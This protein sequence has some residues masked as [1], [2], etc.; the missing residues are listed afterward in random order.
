M[1]LFLS[2][3]FCY[4]CFIGCRP[5]INVITDSFCCFFL[6]ILFIKLMFNQLPI[7]SFPLFPLPGILAARDGQAIELYVYISYS[8]T[9]I[10]HLLPLSQTLFLVGSQLC[11][12]IK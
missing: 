3:Y 6:L 4:V 8:V 2:S 1:T 5:V 12:F 7:V 9:V 10:D 11:P